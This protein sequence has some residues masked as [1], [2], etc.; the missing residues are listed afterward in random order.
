MEENSELVRNTKLMLE[1]SYSPYS[2]FRVGAAI[3]T[4]EGEILLVQIS[5][6]PHL[7]LACVQKE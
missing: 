3:R 4:K 5:K 2:H 1:K 6:M 7:V